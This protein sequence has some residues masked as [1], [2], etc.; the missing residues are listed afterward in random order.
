VSLTNWRTGATGLGHRHP[1]T[2]A[3]LQLRHQQMIRDNRGL[4][5]QFR[6]V[7]TVRT[8]GPAEDD[9]PARREL[10]EKLGALGY[11]Q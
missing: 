8:I 6:V 1:Q 7:R 4:A 3:R 10:R 2:A 5:R 11:V 9:D